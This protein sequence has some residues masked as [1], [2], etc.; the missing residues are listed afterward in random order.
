M[1]NKRRQRSPV[2][3]SCS[4]KENVFDGEEF[5]EKSDIVYFEYENG[6]IMCYTKDNLLNW[7]QQSSAIMARWEGAYDDVGH[8]GR[9]NLRKI[10]MKMPDGWHWITECSYEYILL[11]HDYFEFELI[12]E[13]VPIG[14]LQGIMGVS[15]L[16][17]N[18]PV[19]IYRLVPIITTDDYDELPIYDEFERIPE[20][21][22]DDELVFNE[23]SCIYRLLS[24]L[25]ELL[26]YEFPTMIVEFQ[27]QEKH[28]VFQFF[29]TIDSLDGYGLARAW[30]KESE[31]DIRYLINF[32]ETFLRRCKIYN[33]ITVNYPS[34]IVIT[35]SDLDIPYN[36]NYRIGNYNPPPVYNTTK[37]RYYH[38][39]KILKKK[40]G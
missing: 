14:N 15:M 1:F 39:M 4:L 18:N 35:D 23:V 24:E 32:I 27:R 22:E 21:D 19:N 34:N 31:E 2:Y 5:D 7:F 16:H 13:N 8:G 17:G 36:I 26:K 10:Y 3:T 9:P 25:D 29:S 30:A 28:I 12:E 20:Y 11:G 33:Q 37:D 38:I 40:L 6:D